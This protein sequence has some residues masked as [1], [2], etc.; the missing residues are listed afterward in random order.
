MIGMLDSLLTI[1]VNKPIPMSI[2]IPLVDPPVMLIFNRA[3]AI[4]FVSVNPSG[5][6]LSVFM[7]IHMIALFF[8]QMDV[9][10]VNAQ[11]FWICPRISVDVCQ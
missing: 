5:P 6:L 4:A 11:S 1:M 8:V 10:L 2:V 7:Q 3:V 9:Y